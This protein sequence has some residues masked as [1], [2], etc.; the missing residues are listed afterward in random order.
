M[1]D[2]VRNPEDRFSHSEARIN[3]VDFTIAG[4]PWKV[5]IVDPQKSSATGPGL[6]YIH[7]HRLTW[8]D[9]H[10]VNKPLGIDDLRVIIRGNISHH[11]CMLS[12]A[13][14]V[15]F[16]IPTTANVLLCNWSLIYLLVSKETEIRVFDD[17]T[18]DFN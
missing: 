16:S 17:K 18:A 14:I 13:S 9:V 10:T 11:A 6:D 15:Y 1:L 7:V 4:S 3:I 8:F 2:P 12:T 5:R